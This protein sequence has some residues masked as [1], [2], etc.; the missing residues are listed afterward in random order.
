MDIMGNCICALTA[1][2]C[3]ILLI[4]KVWGR[5]LYPQVTTILWILFFVVALFPFKVV[6]HGMTLLEYNKPYGELDF[7]VVKIE[8]G[9]EE[10]TNIEFET[11]LM[12]QYRIK[13]VVAEVLNAVWVVGMFAA[14]SYRL[15][16]HL[17]LRKT[18]KQDVLYK[19]SED[20]KQDN[21]VDLKYSTYITEN[22]GPFVFGL[23]PAIYMPERILPDRNRFRNAVLHEQEHIKR[24]HHLILLLVDI[25]SII[26]WFLPYVDKL[27]FQALRED[28]EL[29]CD[30][31]L[32]KRGHV[33]T[34][35]YAADLIFLQTAA[36]RYEESL[37]LAKD[38]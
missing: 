6:D 5:Y 23:K 35:E 28:M 4:R 25:V 36:K 29:R 26:Y 16:V 37:L 22:Y 34:R 17:R 10:R 38:I 19:L 7:S 18:I 3:V 9:Y 21:D 20:M 32:I 30:Y 8:S 2:G 13:Y 31:E 14:F 24:K 33:E 15:C 1:V 11:D 27:F 12:V